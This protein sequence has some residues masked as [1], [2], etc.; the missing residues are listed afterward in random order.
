MFF[1]M[2]FLIWNEKQKIKDKHQFDFNLIAQ[3]ASNTNSNTNSTNNS[4]P[5]LH[6]RYSVD[7][8]CDDEYQNEN[9]N[10]KKL[11]GLKKA[12]KKDVKRLNR[13]I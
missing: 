9:M 2:N 1:T 12:A 11:H 3:E 13:L 10:E 8:N 5:N 4:H 7:S 6:Q